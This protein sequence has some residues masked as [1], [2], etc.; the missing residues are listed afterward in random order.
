MA[1][2]AAG[3]ARRTRRGASDR[4]APYRAKRAPMIGRQQRLP[5]L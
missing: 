4:L 3:S 5:R 2:A 1:K